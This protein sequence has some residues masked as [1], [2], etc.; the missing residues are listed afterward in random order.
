[1]AVVGQIARPHGIRGQVI[2][3]LETDFPNERFRPGAELFVRTTT[4][5]AA[6][7]QLIVDTVRFQRDRPVIKF[8]GVDDRDAAEALA[9]HELR[10]PADQ[11]AVLPAHTFYWHDLI[12]CH[13]ETVEG[14]VVGTV[15]GG[16]GGGGGSRLVV[17]TAQGEVLIPFVAEICQSIDVA[18]KRIVISPPA[19]LLGLNIRERG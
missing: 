14:E 12:G 17:S 8:A 6:I 18:G 16:E 15:S 3:N 4:G 9:G 2:V 1:M 19:G 11:L 10:V 13:V 7:A 5:A